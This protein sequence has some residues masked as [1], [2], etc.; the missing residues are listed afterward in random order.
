MSPLDLDISLYKLLGVE[1][2][3]QETEVK[4]AY[5]KLARD[6]HPDLGGDREAFEQVQ[7]AY[8]LLSDPIK[9]KK[10][11]AVLGVLEKQKQ[12]EE[13]NTSSHTINFGAGSIVILNASYVGHGF[14][15][16]SGGGGSSINLGASVMHVGFAHG[17][18]H[19]TSA[20]IYTSTPY[21]KIKKP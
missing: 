14:T 13:E 19:A 9:R 5:R 7:E 10:Y 20:V 15:W 11:D 21:S 18:I 6:T 17:N 8:E 16:S 1:Q 2:T 12:Q 4:S 3:A